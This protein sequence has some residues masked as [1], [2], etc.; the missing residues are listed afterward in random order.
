[1]RWTV[2][3]MGGSRQRD[4]M[5]LHMTDYLSSSCEMPYPRLTPFYNTRHK[6][7]NSCQEKDQFGQSSYSCFQASSKT[8]TF[9]QIKSCVTLWWITHLR[10]LDFAV[11]PCANLLSTKESF[12]QLLTVLVAIFIPQECSDCTVWVKVMRQT[13]HTKYC[14]LISGL[15]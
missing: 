5:P 13:T 9:G 3:K 14:K 4:D 2:N 7:L 1:M 12:V 6:Y 8:T 10:D 15:Y 11:R